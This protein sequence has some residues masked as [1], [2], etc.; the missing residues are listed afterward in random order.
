MADLFISERAPIDGVLI[1]LDEADKPDP[2]LCNLGQFA[3]LLS[4][5]MTNL[6]ADRVC[7]GFAGLP[8]ITQKAE[9]GTRILTS[10]FR[11]LF[12][13]ASYSRRIEAGNKSS[14]F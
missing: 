3:K 9:A 5:R 10:S 11:N 12:A 2:A 6:R 8:T 7:L 4:E 14:P 13:R 1:A